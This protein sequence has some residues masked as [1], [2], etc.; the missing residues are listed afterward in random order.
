[1]VKVE[2]YLNENL[3]SWGG[4]EMKNKQSYTIQYESTNF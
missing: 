2:S 4:K 1:M 3:Q